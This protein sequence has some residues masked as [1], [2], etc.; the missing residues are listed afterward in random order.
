MVFCRVFRLGVVWF[1]QLKDCPHSFVITCAL[2]SWC[3]ALLCPLQAAGL[4][5]LVP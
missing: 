1:L 4:P 3:M 2:L 5:A